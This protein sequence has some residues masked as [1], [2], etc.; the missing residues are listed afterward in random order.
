[1]KVVMVHSRLDRPG[2]AENVVSWLSQGLVGRGHSVAVATSRFDPQ[3]WGDDA[4]RGVP[5]HLVERGWR[6]LRTRAGRARGCA[7]VVASVAADSD[8]VVAHN[9]PAAVWAAFSR[10]WAPRPRLIWY[11]H[12]P[13]ARLHWETAFPSFAAAAEDSERYPWARG[14]FRDFAD[15]IR[16]KPRRKNDTDRRLDREAVE[17]LDGILANSAHTA[18]RVAQTYGRSA[19]PCP[20]GVPVPPATSARPP[21]RR[22]LAWISSLSALKNAVGF[23]EAIRVAVYEHGARDLRVRAVGIRE[24]S[25]RALAA[26]LGVAEV[27]VFEPRL[28]DADLHQLI[29]GSQLVVYPSI[30]EPFG[31]V[32]L[33]AMARGRAVVATN[34]GGPRES[35]V[36]G[37]TGLLADPLDPAAMAA[38]V[39]ELWNDPAR[40]Q[41]LG[42]A[43]LERFREHFTLE[44][45]VERFEKL[46]FAH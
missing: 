29:A 10:R 6:S 1:V 7:R 14:F 26:E 27:V 30:D 34:R 42:R 36:P 13:L 39:V 33:E 25:L 16:S 32:P 35:V 12:E 18:E 4:W 2:G 46:A 3:L 17:M 24:D 40:C 8:L 31:I 11:C 28:G 44:R 15:H 9:F 21:E 5:I 38:A 23:L 45:F 19:T 22:Y 43:G 41:R 20:C 37:V